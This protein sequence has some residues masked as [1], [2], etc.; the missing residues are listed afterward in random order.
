MST[1]SK[2]QAATEYLMITGFVMMILIPLVYIVVEYS[3]GSSG[4][5]AEAQL[6]RIGT[7][8]MENAE[9]IYYFGNPSK[10]TLEVNM[11]EGV[12]GMGIYTND[13][14]TAIPPLP[15]CTKCTE[16]RFLLQK[17]R[18]KQD[19][20]FSSS[21]PLKIDDKDLISGTSKDLDICIYDVD[22]SNCDAVGTVCPSH[23]STAGL[24]TNKIYASP[25]NIL[26]PLT[27]T[28]LS[29]DMTYVECP[30]TWNLS[31]NGKLVDSFP[32][33]G[34]SCTCGT[35]KNNYKYTPPLDTIKSAWRQRNPNSVRLEFDGP[36]IY[37]NTINLNFAY[38]LPTEA[39]IF[40]STVFSPGI[41][42][43]RLQAQ[44][45]HVVI[46]TQ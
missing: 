25:V 22:A 14:A 1:N 42:R 46:G 24:S 20:V 13:P 45:N 5:V 40:N 19:I 11:P 10:I 12:R 39:Q 38:D 31:I 6:Q 35:T 9:N 33:V 16:L 21:I 3:Q 2:A 27:I 28:D 7:K 8:I 44:S 26:D 18:A 41:K 29:F 43:I 37:V 17:G 15:G 30:G 4:E 34:G 23:P 32:V 36:E